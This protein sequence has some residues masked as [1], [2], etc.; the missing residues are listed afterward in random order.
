MLGVLIDPILPVFAILAIGF[1]MGRA[2]LV[3]HAEAQA[4]NRIAML[5]FVPVLVFRL[6]ADAP[7][8][9][10]QPAPLLIFLAVEGAV[11]A[12]GFLLARRG[13]RRP[14]PEAVLLGFA[15][16]FANNVVYVLP[17]TVYLH[18]PEAALPVTAI[19]TMDTAVAFT[20]AM[21]TMAMLTGGEASP[22]RTLA[23]VARVPVLHG[24]AAG[25]AVALLGVSLPAPLRTFA[26]FTGDA[27]A[28]V[29][30]FAMG[31]VLS[32]TRFRASAP[33][34]T[35]S[36][37]KI[38]LFPALVWAALALF[39][40]EGTTNHI[41]LLGSAGP[42]GA[43]AFSM[44]LLYGVRTDDLAQIIVWTSLGTLLT[45]ALLA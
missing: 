26:D 36:L 10:F 7:L 4:L 5:V 12:A 8:E 38:A 33:V 29:A 9:R 40:P 44:A 2:R 21:V 24:M 3:A 37:M 18:G 20:L 42:S 31:V 34:A 11:F 17:I 1:A 25:L 43:M 23:R 35:F 14:L 32:D 6:L 22:A 30:L 16:M 15:A 28:P 13:F 27:G 45:L 19:A 41:Y 39:N